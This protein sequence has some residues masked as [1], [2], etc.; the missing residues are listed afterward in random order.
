MAESTARDDSSIVNVTYESCMDASDSPLEKDF[1]HSFHKC[2]GPFRQYVPQ[3]KVGKYRLDAFI[4]T[5][6]Q[7]VGIELDGA[8]FHDANSDYKRDKEI[9]AGGDVDEIIRIPFAAMHYYR[10]GVFRVISEWHAELSFPCWNL[11][12]V[13]WAEFISELESRDGGEGMTRDEYLAWAEPN[14]DVYDVYETF[15]FACSPRTAMNRTS[16]TSK[17]RLIQRLRG[18]YPCRECGGTG[19]ERWC[20][21]CGADYWEVRVQ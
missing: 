7:R 2:V 21:K 16:P 9:L 18:S 13:R 1:W 14:L 17:L 19:I 8:E 15:G 3:Y 11:F 20:P 12:A 6:T 5:S 10:D 4:E